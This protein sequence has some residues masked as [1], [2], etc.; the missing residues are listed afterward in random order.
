MR[1][2]AI[3]TLRQYQRH[4]DA[5]WKHLSPDLQGEMR[6][7]QGASTRGWPTDDLV[8]I[9][10]FYDMDRCPQN[11][12]IYVE[13]GAGQSYDGDELSR[14]NPAYHGSTHPDEV[15]AYISPNSR[16]AA[17]WGRP[18]FVAGCPALDDINRE[19]WLAR[20]HNTVAI[21]FHWDCRRVC[22]EA[23]SAK[24][25]WMEHLH[26]IVSELRNQWFNVIGT[27]HPRDTYG[28]GVWEQLGVETVADPDEVLR[29]ADLLIADNTS[30][31]YE[32]A[33]LG[34]PQLVLNAPWYRRD[35]HH[36]L[37]FWDHLPGREMDDIS[38]FGKFDGRIY[39]SSPQSTRMAQSAGDY[40]FEH[41]VGTAGEDAARWIEKLAA[42]LS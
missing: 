28:R 16:V 3:A 1:I 12:M 42:E 22:E 24:H 4:V 2:H 14:A 36:G 19:P 32:A 11:R 18:A 37:R 5:V 17:S 6:T 29:R 27:W 40:A 8:M 25:F 21:T 23:R 13:H 9:G 7:E 10:G 33:K 38:A 20:S 39:L 26:V 41:V 30:L 34:I 35:V 15:V 31:Q